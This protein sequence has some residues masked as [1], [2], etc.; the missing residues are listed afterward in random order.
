[1]KCS[2]AMTA[3]NSAKY[4]TEQLDSV[5][6]QLSAGDEVV[7]S[8]D[9]CTDGTDQI[10]AE[11]ARRDRRIRVLQGPGKGLIQ[12]F[13]HAMQNCTGDFIFLCDHDDVWLPGKVEKVSRL[14]MDP[15]VMVVLHDAK[16]CDGA[17]QVTAPSYM[18]WHGSK[19]GYYQNILRNSFIGC[20]MAFRR[21]LCAQALPLPADLPM[22][23][24][25]IGLLG[26][27]SGKVIFLKEPLLLYRR[28]GENMSATEHAGVKQMLQWRLALVKNLSKR[29]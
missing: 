23:D 5:L 1:M 2:V 16:V 6:C 17:L 3:C 18:D 29:R 19:E 25:W 22:H 12:N 26:Y 20:C 15:A 14:F 11:Y 27:R 10:L 21:T 8:A 7:I 13:N 4:L 24:Q 28:H 9:P